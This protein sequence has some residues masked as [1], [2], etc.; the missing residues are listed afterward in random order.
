MTQLY[1]LSDNQCA[2]W[3]SE[4]YEANTKRGWLEIINQMR[5]D[6]GEAKFRS[7]KTA[8]EVMDLEIINANKR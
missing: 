5:D 8:C 3:F 4:G 6:A 2:G 1:R 7:L